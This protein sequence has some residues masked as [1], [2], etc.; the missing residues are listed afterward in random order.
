MSTKNTLKK[1][2]SPIRTSSQQESSEDEVLLTQVHKLQDDHL[3]NSR[4]ETNR[5]Q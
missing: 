3:V 1:N 2:G 5:P 4:P